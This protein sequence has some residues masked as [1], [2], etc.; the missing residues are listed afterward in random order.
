MRYIL[1]VIYILYFEVQ[2]LF[3]QNPIQLGEVI[4]IRNNNLFNSEELLKKSGILMKANSY[5]EE[6]D[7]ISNLDYSKR[8]LL[9]TLSMCMFQSKDQNCIVLF[10]PPV[11]F[12]A[13]DSIRITRSQ[14]IANNSL[15]EFF[16][17]YK[18]E[19]PDIM[20]EVQC[21]SFI[22]YSI[23]SPNQRHRYYMSGEKIEDIQVFP[24]DISKYM[25]NSDSLFVYSIPIIAIDSGNYGMYKEGEEKYKQERKEFWDAYPYCKALIIQK[26]D[27]GFIRLYC[28]FGE[29]GILNS[30][31]YIKKL[32]DIIWYK[33]ND[34]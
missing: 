13:E 17:K 25:F 6:C 16:S 12:T 3:A 26:Q 21:K 18:K 4:T 30:D 24:H 15:K 19:H 22:D 33:D 34:T 9:A 14:E 31:D 28:L 7:S 8:L 20:S 5:F 10:Q 29:C 27:R 1:I 23:Y 11:L 32:K 2:L